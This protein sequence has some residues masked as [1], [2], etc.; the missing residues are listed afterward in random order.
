MVSHALLSHLWYLYHVRLHRRGF[1]FCL[2]SLTAIPRLLPHSR[3][4]PLSCLFVSIAH[5]RTLWCASLRWSLSWLG[6]GNTSN[7]PPFGTCTPHGFSSHPSWLS[8]LGLFQRALRTIVSRCLSPLQPRGSLT[9]LCRLDIAKHERRFGFSAIAHLK[10]FAYG[11]PNQLSNS[12][13]ISDLQ[14]EKKYSLSEIKADGGRW[15]G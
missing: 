13:N 5:H 8:P 12:L 2:S 6:G 4:L 7:S 3:Q 14:N 11:T 10:S 9:T 15:R 1:Q